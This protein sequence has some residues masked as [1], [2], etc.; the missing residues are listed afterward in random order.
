MATPKQVVDIDAILAQEWGMRGSDA[1]VGPAPLPGSS[2]VG[3]TAGTSADGYGPTADAQL[4]AV[5]TRIRALQSKLLAGELSPQEELDLKNLYQSADNLRRQ[6]DRKPT[7]RDPGLDQAT[8]IANYQ[9]FRKMGA[10]HEMAAAAAGLSDP[11]TGALASSTGIASAG[12]SVRAWLQ[13][14]VQNRRLALDEAKEVSKTYFDS[15]QEARGREAVAQDYMTNAVSA[16]N[17]GADLERAKMDL[18]DPATIRMWAEQAN[19]LAETTGS[20][21]RIP[22]EWAESYSPVRVSPDVLGPSGIDAPAQA[23]GRAIKDWG[24]TPQE[25]E[26]R[27][28]ANAAATRAERGLS[29]FSAPGATDDEELY[30]WVFTPEEMAKIVAG[31]PSWREA[32]LESVE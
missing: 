3:T 9:K 25:I 16:A 20:G 18:V 28:T 23:A 30:R 6:I 27:V 26:S 19:R 14:Q 7:P 4:T 24:V 1:G 31:D 10:T 21:F 29:G 2:S 17:K 15:L 11:E 5:E 22:G 13:N 8:R 12:T 32:E